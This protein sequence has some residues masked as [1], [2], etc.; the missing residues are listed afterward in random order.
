MT[1]SLMNA[2]IKL[3]PTDQSRWAGV[4]PLQDLWRHGIAMAQVV[5]QATPS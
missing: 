5:K 3:V 1:P 4:V 2:G